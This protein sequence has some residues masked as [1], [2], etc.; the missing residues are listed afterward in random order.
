M[1]VIL[2][3]AAVAT[4]TTDVFL[5]SD[6]M[7]ASAAVLN[8]VCDN[9][10][11]TALRLHLLAPTKE[12]AQTLATATE[13]ACDGAVVLPYG[14]R[15]FEARVRTLVGEEP[16]W[17]TALSKVERSKS[18]YAVPVARWDRDEKHTS[19][20]NH[21]RFYAPQLIE[22]ETLVML[23]DDVIVQGDVTTLTTRNKAVAAG[24]QQWYVGHEGEFQSSTALT[25]ADV[26]YFGFGVL[27]GQDDPGCSHEGATECV[28]GDARDW[29]AEVARTDQ[30]VARRASWP[31]FLR[32]LAAIKD[33]AFAASP[34]DGDAFVDEL[35]NTRA[36]NFG[37]V[38]IDL[39]TWKQRKLTAK[40]QG[41]LE[42]NYQRQFWPSDSLAFGLGLPF[43]ALRG[44][45]ECFEDDD[46]VRFEQGLGVAPWVYTD[47][48]TK[49]LDDAFAL[50]WNGN[51]KPWDMDRC[52]DATR[53]YFLRYLAR[54]PGLYGGHVAE[55]GGDYWAACAPP[56]PRYHGFRFQRKLYGVNS[57]AGTAWATYA[58]AYM[59][60]E[61][62]YR[63]D[64]DRT[65]SNISDCV[66]HCR[67]LFPD[68]AGG[69]TLACPRTKLELEL[70]RDR[71]WHPD[72][73]GWT[74]H[75]S[76]GG[77][78]A[79]SFNSCP[80]VHGTVD[81]DAGL[82][83]PGRPDDGGGCDISER[84]TVL[85]DN[86]WNTKRKCWS[87]GD[88]EKWKTGW[89]NRKEG[90]DDKSCGTGRYPV[91][92][93]AGR[94]KDKDKEKELGRVKLAARLTYGHRR[95]VCLC[96]KTPP[97]TYDPA[98]LELSS[99]GLAAGSVA[100]VCDDMVA[101]HVKYDRSVTMPTWAVTLLWVLAWFGVFFG[102]CC[103]FDRVHYYCCADE[104]A[105]EISREWGLFSPHSFHIFCYCCVEATKACCYCCE[106][107]TKAC[108]NRSSTPSDDGLPGGPRRRRPTS[109]LYLACEKGHFDAARRLLENG[110]KVNRATKDG[111]TPLYV[112][113]AYGRAA[114]ARL[115]LEKGAE[116]ERA[117]ED[118][119]TPL[120]IACY[121]GHVDVALLLVDKGADVNRANKNGR[122]P[123]YIAC[124][125]GHVDAVRLLL[126]RGAVFEH[127]S[128]ALCEGDTVEADYCGGGRFYPGKISRDRGNGKY[129]IA[130]DDGDRE[131]GVHARL[132]RRL[133]RSPLDIAK[134]NGYS[135]VV[136]LLEESRP[137]PLG[138][139]RPQRQQ[140]DVQCSICLGPYKERAWTKC[141]HSFCRKCIMQV[142]L[143]NYPTNRA[144][145]PFCRQ[146]VLLGEL[147]RRP[148][149]ADAIPH[150]PER[151]GF[152]ARF[153]SFATAEPTSEPT[154]NA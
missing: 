107:A 55:S 140:S 45:V 53:P 69:G 92:P 152:G 100:L 79:A 44:E 132:I 50:H 129:D 94:V 151:R 118:G 56:P 143:A 10:Q 112:A 138:P 26:P 63:Y 9:S 22:G 130:Y 14:L 128:S 149:V 121:H 64:L 17:T 57:V 21:A 87:K 120:Y 150:E 48:D 37:L 93:P 136:A 101:K 81:A 153:L 1:K 27:S 3:L 148:G 108:R 123:L 133:P 5:A 139:P 131:T 29:F 33:D 70:L 20:Y 106:E 104:D 40:Y 114:A 102:I 142:C 110:A 31:R 73:W 97:A 144:P 34:D 113:C 62:F 147:A 91:P 115:L 39:D 117:M 66:A 105:R 54:S 25:Y 75:F 146:P 6:R 127:D 49:T 154:E 60:A 58:D 84:C 76:G 78:G 80:G 98:A 41:W 96:E 83:Y 15:E 59:W 119:A 125:H 74:G 61:D 16:M 88:C 77:A 7:A 122:T 23:D 85:V 47:R 2:A 18:T 28:P 95:N 68:V 36:W 24:C 90:L 126:E 124:Y 116:T 4:A 51:R 109:T 141:N 89:I 135:A 67:D 137:L 134:E 86:E 38:V 82:W 12:A 46:S 8:S 13:T 11:P 72:W 19:P 42:A 103:C 35:Y 111:A 71:F 30:A 43:L 145:C 52:D 65:A 99:P 32:R